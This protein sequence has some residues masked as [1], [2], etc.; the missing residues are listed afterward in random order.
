MP[1]CSQGVGQPANGLAHPS[2][3]SYDDVDFDD[4]DHHDWKQ[5]DEMVV[6]LVLLVERRR[7]YSRRRLNF[8]REAV[9]LSCKAQHA[10]AFS[11]LTGGSLD[12]M[13]S[14]TTT[15]SDTALRYSPGGGQ[16]LPD[17]SV[18]FSSA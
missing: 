12:R 14:G 10:M 1:L 8:Q 18:S 13:V 15:K 11:M 6:H 16:R 9:N 2:L 3:P 5:E 17:K 4:N 7:A